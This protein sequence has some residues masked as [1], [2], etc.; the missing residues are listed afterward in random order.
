[1]IKEA[2]DPATRRRLTRELLAKYGTQPAVRDSVAVQIIGLTRDHV[3]PDETLSYIDGLPDNLQ[4][5]PPVIEQRQIAL[6]KTGDVLSA[7]A[8]LKLLI[9]QAGPSSDRYGILGGHY[10]QLMMRSTDPAV[11]RRYLDAAIDAYER[12]MAEDLNDYYPSSNLP[13][14][15]RRRGAPG[16]E[17]RANDVATIVK[18]ACQRVLDRD[19]DDG[20]VL[21][22]S[23][24]ET[25]SWGVTCGFRPRARIG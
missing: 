15:Y 13:R 4:N 22:L 24:S 14:L 20:W 10:K 25:P 7:A 3:G 5:H 16:D 17:Q 11:R 2:F 9:N 18:A 23:G 12:G 19:G 6:A 21:T 1:M 8:Q